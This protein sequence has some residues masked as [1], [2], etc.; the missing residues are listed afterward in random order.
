M[1][2]IRVKDWTKERLEEIRARESH[3]SFDSV[4]KSLLKDRRL[5]R[6]VDDSERGGLSTR[7]APD[8]PPVETAVE[9]LTVFAEL[10]RA[11]SGVV[12]LWCPGCGTEVAHMSVENPVSIPV[13][14]V[15]CRNC[16]THL[17]QHA[18]VAIEIGYPLERRLVENALED[19][20]R[21]CVVDYWDR[22]LREH[23]G[24][25]RT[26]NGADETEDA[27]LVWQL[28]QYV[29]EFAWDWP[30]DE[31]VVGIRPGRTYRQVS[32]GDHLDVVETVA[33]HRN[34]PD[35]YLVRRYRPGEA[36]ERV[37]P[38]R[39]SSENLAELI[40]Q[41]DLIRIDE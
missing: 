14:E 21:D 19:D 23:T 6:A 10:R 4:V 37:E 41:R 36:P 5:A 31:P 39:L 12:F 29:R 9:D 2:T 15:E 17:D 33:E 26:G 35:A 16:L 38:E 30:A 7:A 11:D 24:D 27:R 1:T 25:A 20:L 40:I 32:T 3:S 28:D 22:A 34:A 13:F 8:A 18:L